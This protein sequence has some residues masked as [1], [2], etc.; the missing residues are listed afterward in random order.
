LRRGRPGSGPADLLADFAPLVTAIRWGTVTIGLL[1]AVFNQPSRT[2]L[3]YGVVL[4]AYALWRTVAPIRYYGDS[5]RSLIAVYGDVALCLGVVV[6]TGYWN[7]PYIF[8]LITSIMLA[9]FARGFA[10]AIRCA[11]ASVLAIAIPLVEIDGWQ[12]SLEQSSQWGGE[13]LLVGL[14]AG[15]ARRIYQET[16]QQATE[17][18]GR[19]HRLSEANALLSELHRVAQVLPASLDLSETIAST[20]ARVRELVEPDAIAILLRD[21]ATDSW[22]VALAEGVR[23]PRVVPDADLPGPL[24]RALG[25]SVSILVDD[26][27]TRGPGL[28]SGSRTGLYAALR[29]RDRVIGIVAAERR[30]AGGMTQR[31]LGLL[32]GLSE[33]AALAIDN[34][35]WFGSLRRVGA[36][37]ERTRIAREL[38]DRV[39]QSL[40]YLAFELDRIT[41]RAREGEVADDL[42]VLQGEVRQVIGEVRET[43][44]DLRTDVSEGQDLVSTLN[45]YLHRVR[46]RR[47]LDVTFV[48]ESTA[49]LPLPIERELWRIAQEAITNVERHAQATHVRVAWATDGR[50]GL[51]EVADDGQGLVATG[52][53]RPDSY[54]ILG[55][56]ERAAV[57]G[58]SIEIDSSPGMGTTVRCRLKEVRFL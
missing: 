14:I 18:L 24:R 42:E 40:A 30:A 33:Q 6:V 55:M 17:A 1:L 21:D 47:D 48:N 12:K 52:A 41:S 16:R 3:L 2:K 49:R 11:V 19:L 53:G 43:L 58:A 35:R 13:L 23:L 39:G 54:G 36:D 25:A 15:Y 5:T 7:S 51:L 44:Y 9:G 27:P 8:S 45:T 56:R 38:H 10:F 20:A 32:D 57:I 4:M 28:T 50:T 31:D 22:S 37:E 34:A 26:L 29:A 46:Q